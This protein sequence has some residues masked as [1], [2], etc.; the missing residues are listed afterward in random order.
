M[1]S[2]ALHQPG[3]LAQLSG[4]FVNGRHL[5]DPLRHRMLELSH[6]R[7]SDLSRQLL[8]SHG[9]VSKILA[10]RYYDAASIR[11]G[12]I[13][14]SKPKVATPEVVNK[15]ETY[16]QENPTIFAWEIR[17]RLI[18]E[19]VCT[20]STVPSVSSINR[21]LRNRAA[22]RAAAE[23]A[24][25]AEQALYPHYPVSWPAGSP[26]TAPSMLP[27]YPLGAPLAAGS[28]TFCPASILSVPP[29][30]IGLTP[31]TSTSLS[32]QNREENRH[33]DNLESQKKKLR[34]SRTTFNSDQ[35]DMLEKEFEKT[36][37]PCV[38]TREDL[39]SKTQLSEARVQVW[40]SNRRAKWRRHKK[41]GSMAHPSP[42]LPVT[43]AYTSIYKPVPVPERAPPR[44]VARE[45]GL[46]TLIPSPHSAFTAASSPIMTSSP[47]SPL[48]VV[49][50]SPSTSPV[51]SS[52]PSPKKYT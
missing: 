41:I 7:S 32:T 23:Y 25:A 37:Y 16:K 43:S 19:G 5:T 8:L 29:V 12:T 33:Q 52:E 9:C 13:G 38:N 22:E 39:A 26:F 20:N 18:S 34:R 27:Q 40:F 28:N 2:S 35:L 48:V 46:K 15:I 51:T 31:S 24:R 50:S 49:T 14:G 3:N 11:P 6:I 4:V 44:V 45:E 17:D 30:S 42:M 10:G 1:D 47:S 36:H 21:I